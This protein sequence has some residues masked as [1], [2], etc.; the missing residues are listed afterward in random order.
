MQNA[1]IYARYSSHGQNEQT[2]EGQ[3]RVCKEYATLHGLNIVNTYVDKHKTGTDVNRPQFQKMIEDAK[4][5]SFNY[6]IVYMID[7]FA[8]N[9]YYSTIYSW[10]LQQQ[11]VKIVS[12]TENISESEEGEFYQMFLEWNAEKYSKRLSKRVIEG[13]NT[14]VANG[15][16]TGGYLIYGYKTEER[17][18]TATQKS[19]FVIIDDEKAEIVRYIFK[20]Y[21][22]GISKKQIAEELNAQGSRYNGKFWTQK[23]FEHMLTNEKYTGVYYF[24]NRL[25][26]NTY[27][28]IID[29]DTFLAVSKRLEQNKHLSGASSAKER[30]LLTGKLYCGHC[31]C[32]MVAGSGT[33]HMGTIYQYYECKNHKKHLC[34]KTLETKGFCEW[35]V[36]EQIIKY[37][38]DPRRV[39]IIADDVVKY[40]ETRVSNTEII[41]IQ[42]ERTKTQK[43]IDNAVNLLVSGVSP[44]VVKTLDKKIVELTALLNDLT[45]HQS[46]L[47]LE[48]GL[49]ITQK[50]IVEFVAEFIKGDIIDKDFQK[51]IIDNLLNAF[52]LSDDR[53]VLYFNIKGG[54]EV[55]FID[56]EDTDHAVE[57]LINK[58]SVKGSN[59]NPTSPPKENYTHPRIYMGC[60]FFILRE[61]FGVVIPFERPQLPPS[62][63]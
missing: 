10:Q 47:E 8:R 1:V 26:D 43:E 62:E 30:Y 59:F 3:V 32:A 36:T 50:D 52:Y 44:D 31:G 28:P 45:K 5:G 18:L 7:R 29:K 61:C 37:L 48:Q 58:G 38:N 9:R 25:C 56:K 49:K 34:D 23:N 12:A 13:L 39:K 6:V 63:N 53:V 17:Q 27:P 22:A 4:T 51:R 46:K 16:F 40:Y 41:R 14:S 54:K 55:I 19:K 57:T 20:R 60:V 42:G 2:I 33:G 15:T 11:N 35:Y 24:G 21:A